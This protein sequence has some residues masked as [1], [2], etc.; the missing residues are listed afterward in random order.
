MN[1]YFIILA[2]FIFLILLVYFFFNK[3]QLEKLFPKPELDTGGVAGAIS[4]IIRTNGQIIIGSFVI[5]V[6]TALLLDGKITSEAAMPIMSLI[7]GYIIG[8]EIDQYRGKRDK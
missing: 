4:Q 5:L 8:S 3:L 7:A 2:I 6:L 1:I